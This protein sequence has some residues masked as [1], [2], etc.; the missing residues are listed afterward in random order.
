MKINWRPIVVYAAIQV[1]SFDVA[2]FL[3]YHHVKLGWDVLILAP[4]VIALTALGIL[5]IV[6]DG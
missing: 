4:F 5:G 2:I 6:S 3:S 1:A